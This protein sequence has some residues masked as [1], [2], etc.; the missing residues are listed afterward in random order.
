MSESVLLT[1]EEKKELEDMYIH[2][3]TKQ[4]DY[5]K[6]KKMRER[7]EK[8]QKYIKNHMQL[9]INLC[10]YLCTYDMCGIRMRR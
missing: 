10:A 3:I 5:L 7:E 6:K 9:N 1:K 4:F 2:L 8:S